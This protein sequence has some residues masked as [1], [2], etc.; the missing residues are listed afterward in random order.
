LYTGHKLTRQSLQDS[1][2][3]KKSSNLDLSLSDAALYFAAPTTLPDPVLNFYTETYT[4]FT[5]LQRIVA[6]SVRLPIP[7]NSID[8]RGFG[9]AE[10]WDKSGHLVG[11]K[12]LLG[13]P[14]AETVGHMRRLVG[15]YLEEI[16]RLREAEGIEV[17]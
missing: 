3:T 13:P 14:G 16:V 2:Q 11:V 1:N 4:L 6:S 17:S 7:S 10:A 9:M 15:M 8:A 5:S 12:G